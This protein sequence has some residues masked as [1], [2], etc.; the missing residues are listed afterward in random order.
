MKKPPVGVM[1][2]FIWR[3]I[4]REPSIEDLYRRYRAVDNAVVRYRKA[5]LA[6]NLGWLLELGVIRD[7]RLESA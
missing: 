3:D 1:P 7:K 2:L 4:H 6:P 5:G